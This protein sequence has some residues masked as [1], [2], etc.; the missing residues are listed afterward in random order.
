MN[1][2]KTA[3][4]VLNGQNLVS[5]EIDYIM[6]TLGDRATQQEIDAMVLQVRS[7][8]WGSIYRPD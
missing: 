4:R 7:M 3:I 2:R 6:R 1:L 8:P 5:P